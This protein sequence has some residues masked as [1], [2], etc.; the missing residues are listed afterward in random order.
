MYLVIAC[1]EA[2]SARERQ[3]Q[4]KGKIFL[5]EPPGNLVDDNTA[6]IYSIEVN[7]TFHDDE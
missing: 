5:V 2:N 7:R 4:R 1:D 3:K 6:R